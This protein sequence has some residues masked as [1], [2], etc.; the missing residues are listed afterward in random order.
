MRQ[1]GAATRLLVHFCTKIPSWDHPEP[2]VDVYEEKDTRL[3]EARVTLPS[4]VE[5]V[6]F[7]SALGLACHVTSG[8]TCPLAGP[9][10]TLLEASVSEV[11]TQSTPGLFNLNQL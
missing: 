2:S 6:V 8:K 1:H 10:V 11:G 3:C 4:H 7:N 9:Q 5:M